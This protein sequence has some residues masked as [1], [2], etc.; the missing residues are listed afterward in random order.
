MTCATAGGGLEAIEAEREAIKAEIAAKKRAH[1]HRL[2]IDVPVVDPTAPRYDPSKPTPLYPSP[3]T[4]AAVRAFFS[5]DDHGADSAGLSAAADLVD[6]PNAVFRHTD[7]ACCVCFSDTVAVRML[8]RACRHGFC[9]ECAE[10]ALN[11]I[12]ESGQFPAACPGCLADGGM[13]A[14]VETA[15]IPAHVIEALVARGVLSIPFGR[16]FVSQQVMH[17]FDRSQFV[18]CPICDL[19]CFK[20]SW[21]DKVVETM[22]EP[23]RVECPACESA[24]CI[25]CNEYYRGHAGLTCEDFESKTQRAAEAAS[26]GLILQTA[27]ACPRCGTGVTHWAGHGCHHISGCCGYD[28]CFVCLEPHPCSRVGHA[29]FCDDGCGCVPCPICRPGSP[30]DKCPG[31]DRCPSCSGVA[32]STALNPVD[33]PDDAGMIDLVDVI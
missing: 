1:K 19:M 15:F 2:D 29:L 17:A 30:C 4:A 14:P 3:R 31:G 20:P 33:A 9:D 26:M 11:T 23:W 8:G 28:W 16:K 22:V 10:Q 18:C 27:K 24:F 6:D 13:A 32:P 12:V 25:K 5:G 7:S 21:D